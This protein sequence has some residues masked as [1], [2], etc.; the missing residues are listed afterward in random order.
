[1]LRI[2]TLIA[3]GL[4]VPAT[5]F[6]QVSQE[7]FIRSAPPGPAAA[8]ATDAIPGITCVGKFLEIGVNEGGGFGVGQ[9]SGTVGTGFRFPQTA[10]AI[11]E[12]LAFAFW[13]EGWKI[14]YKELEDGVLVDTTAWW[15]PDAGF[16]PPPQ[17]GFLPFR[18][19]LLRDD[20]QEC[21]YEVVVKTT[22]GKLRLSF[23][24]NFRK[25]YPSVVV[26]TEITNT[27]GILL[28]DV[29]YSRNADYD[30]HNN[31]FNG[32]SSNDS[33]AFACGNNTFVNPETPLVVM[34]IAA[35]DVD[36]D[37]VSRDRVRG[38]SDGRVFYA[39]EDSFDFVMPIPPALGPDY[40]RRGPG[41]SVIKNRTPFEFDGFGSVHYKLKT[42][43]PRVSKKVATV[44][45]AAFTNQ[46][47]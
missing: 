19:E 8:Q 9:G 36:E 18:A 32:W 46:C 47:P 16:P 42:F 1:M 40:D 13:G 30:I 45:S 24:F 3:V 20:D 14:S 31:T 11:A 26:T 5:A 34:D 43:K 6:S 12:S 29:V 38:Q 39:E 23:E 25:A 44:Y 4:L 7:D 28:Q 22:D 33:A 37:V 41:E 15:Q 35:Y 17:L 21:L 2:S 10:G 27:S